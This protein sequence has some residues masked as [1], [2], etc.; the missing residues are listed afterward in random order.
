[1]NHSLVLIALGI[2]VG[3]YSG[4]MGLGGG[5]LMIPAMVLLTLLFRRRGWL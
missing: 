1:M 4:V 2:A 3:I 5:T